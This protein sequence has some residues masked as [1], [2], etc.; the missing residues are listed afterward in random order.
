MRHGN[1]CP[2]ARRYMGRGAAMTTAILLVEA[3][4]QSIHCR[5]DSCVNLVQAA[6]LAREPVQRGVD[7]R[8]RLIMDPGQSIE[9]YSVLCHRKDHDALRARIG[10]GDVRASRY[11]L[12]RELRETSIPILFDADNDSDVVIEDR[13]PFSP[14]MARVIDT[15]D[16]AL[17]A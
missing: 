6:W 1:E 17:R 11:A 15:N 10:I 8:I 4:G 5:E 12:V 9:E 2:V 13:L 7:T 16:D 14:L 3:R